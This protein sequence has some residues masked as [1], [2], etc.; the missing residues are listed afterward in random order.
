ML[1]H[2][3]DDAVVTITV[4]REEVATPEATAA[5][6]ETTAEPELVKTKGKKEEEGAEGAEGAAAAQ[7]KEK[8]KAP[9]KEKK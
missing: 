8:E 9:A 4:I 7:G 2:H 5:A 6:V 3:A 1:L